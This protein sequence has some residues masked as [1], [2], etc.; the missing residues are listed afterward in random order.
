MCYNTYSNALI[1]RFGEKVYKIPVN[2][3][4]SCPNR[5]GTC[6]HGGCTFCGEVGTG[7]ENLDAKMSVSKQLEENIAYIGPKYKA[8]KFIVYFNNFSNTYCE[9]KV[10]EAAVREACIEGVVGICVSTR[11][12]CISNAHLEVLKSVEFENK[13]EITVELGLQTINYHT[14]EKIN[15]GHG[16]AEFVDAVLRIRAFGFRTCA[17][18]IGNLPWDEDLDLREAA[19]LFAVLK[20]DE[21]KIHTLYILKNTEMA[22]QYL[23][24]EFEMGSVETYVNRVVA[25]IRYSDP[26]MVFQRFAGRAPEEETLFCNWGMSW[27]RIKDLIDK[28][29]EEIG[30]DQ[31]DLCHFK[32][33]PSVRKFL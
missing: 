7:F 4:V 33:G 26:K 21:V 3:P 2:M 13:V 24:G 10:L 30:A 18:L 29:L 31:G 19:K 20:I 1:Q 14:L 11:P 23:A 15:R 9:P 27:W 25:F 8:K 6:G 32:N 16:L 5:D 22:R 12:D 28:K 17:H